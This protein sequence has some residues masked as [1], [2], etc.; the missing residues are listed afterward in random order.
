MNSPKLNP[1][2]SA[3]LDFLRG[4]AAQIVLIGHA[5]I[6]FLNGSRLYQ[7]NLQVIAVMIFFL[8]SGFLISYTVFRRY[9][10]PAFKFRH[11]FADRFARIF[12]A[13]VP[14]LIF[15]AAVDAYNLTLPTAQAL[16]TVTPTGS[17]DGED[18]VQGLFHN[19]TWQAW[20]GNL[21]MLQDFP[22]FQI[23]R[24]AGLQENAFFIKSFGTASP[25]WTISIEWW[26]YM[27]FG[28]IVLLRIRTGSPFKLW[29]LPILGF[30]VIEPMYYLIGGV[31]N[32]LSLLWITGMMLSL[33]YINQDKLLA[34]LGST[35]TG[36]RFRVYCV[37]AFFF[38][39]VCMAARLV[40]LKL[41]TGKMA[42]SEFQFGLFLALAVFAPL[43]ALN[44]LETAPAL[45]RK[46]C[47]GL[48]SYSFSLYL[49]HAPIL[50]CLFLLYPDRPYDWSMM[51]MSF[52]VSNVV[53]IIFAW[54][55][56]RHYHKV[57]SWIKARFC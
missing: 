41:D 56:E 37:G 18:W 46:A 50:S 45:V 33:A 28:M 24:L 9:H 30:V 53:A 35:G 34:P 8:L 6:L 20:L 27:A 51:G 1:A 52:A 44:K 47:T 17:F 48:S 42:F 5:S 3:Y 26:L 39:L 21:L 22:L 11:Y 19:Y 7:A 32:C 14:A 55:F 38:A 43:M 29:Q 4:I 49:T 25:F 54:L 36:P 23:A 10:D 31:D 2:Q 16:A 12:T 15:A 13:F 40:A 57:G